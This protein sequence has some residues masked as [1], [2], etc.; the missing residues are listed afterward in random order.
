MPALCRRAM[1]P[2]RPN[3]YLRRGGRRHLS[4]YEAHLVD[5]ALIRLEPVLRLLAVK[6]ELGSKGDQS[7]VPQSGEAGATEGSVTR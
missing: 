5:Q 4:P 2:D 6:A 3:R 7:D 1:S